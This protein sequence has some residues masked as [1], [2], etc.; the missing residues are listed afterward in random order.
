M[1]CVFRPAILAL[2]AALGSVEA[3]QIDSMRTAD[4]VRLFD[5]VV[6]TAARRDERRSNA[7][8]STSVISQAD[9]RQAGATDVAAVLAQQLGLQVGGGTPAGSQVLIQGLGDRRVLV[10]LDGQPITGR[11]GGAFDLSRL[12]ASIVDRIEVV[13]GPQSVFYGTDA[14]GGVINIITRR[15]GAGGRR[16]ATPEATLI[17]GSHG[18]F[19]VSTR[20]GGSASSDLSYGVDIARN[21]IDLA[22]GLPSEVGAFANRW[23][24]APRVAWKA[25][26]NLRVDVG[27]LAIDER[28]RYRTG[29]LYTFSDNTQAAAHATAVWTRG[30]TRITPTLAF[31]SFDHLSRAAIASRPASD[32]GAHDAQ[33]MLTGTL[34]Y[35]SILGGLVV[36]AGAELRHESIDADRVPGTRATDAAALFGQTTW[37]GSRVSIAPGMRASWS[38]QWGTSLTPRVAAIARP[39]GDDSPLTLRASVARGFRV[40]DFKELYLRF[41]NASAGY[42]VSGSDALRPEHSVNTTAEVA[43]VSSSIDLR[44]NAFHNAIR[45]LIETVGPD[46]AGT[47]TYD[48]V[49]R[50]RTVGAELEAAKHWTRADIS[51]GYSYLRARD[52]STGGPILGRAAHS[53]RGTLRAEAWSGVRVALTTLHTGAAPASRDDV[54]NVRTERGALTQI[55]ARVARAVGPAGWSRTELS[56][57]ADDVFDVRRGLEWPGFTGRQVYVGLAWPAR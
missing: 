32:S 3:Q 18:R 42:A 46:G 27:G 57:G 28:Q 37:I 33:R 2:C 1:R 6:V 9:I 29:Q 13:K 14:M 40:P 30:T 11:I 4:S 52:V 23:N 53:A 48:N 21:H 19:D 38:E 49:G 26:S 10:L 20:I 31:S 34:Q 47:Y 45:D 55:N 8:V 35:S 51:A 22:P 25:M 54:G 24:V 41:V 39:L 5:P 7:I 17:A 16:I 12:P 15:P 50:A 43:W 44:A 56:I 36:D